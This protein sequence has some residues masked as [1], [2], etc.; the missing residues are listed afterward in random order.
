MSDA[1]AALLRINLALAA[2]VAVILLLRRPV[3][4]LVGPR[5]AYG[6][7]A[8]APL[9][10]LAMLAPPRIMRVRV[11][12]AP[13]A[14]APLAPAGP[15]LASPASHVA[16]L[17]P[18]LAGLWLAGAA[19]SLLL[20]AW[21]Q[22][23]FARAM[24]AGRAGPAVVGVLRPRIVTPADFARRYTEREQLVVLAHER[25]HIVRQDPR[26]NAA[27]ALARC[28]AW[29]NPLAHLAATALR[30][31]QELACDAQVVAAH[32]GARRA[33]AEAM[34]KTQL[35]ARPLP[36]GCYWPSP[37]AHPLAERI[38]LLAR[39][40]P[41]P[42]QRHLGAAGLGL[43]VLGA[44][45]AAWAA[46]PPEVRFDLQAY[47]PP[48]AVAPAAA[49]AAAPAPAPPRLKP[50]RP[51]PPLAA[52]P[53]APAIPAAF[54]TPPPTP[55]DSGH[56]GPD[57]HLLPPGAEPPPFSRRIHAAARF[58]SVEPGSAVRVLA[59]MTDPDGVPLVTDLTAF[60][61]QSLY[62]MGYV[63][64]TSSRYKLFTS[65]AQHGDRLEVTAA[66]TSPGAP[67]LKGSV[68]LGSGETAAVPLPGG[69]SVR[70]TPLLRP[71]TPE[72]AEAAAR[73]GARTFVRV[74]RVETP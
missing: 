28:L 26:I 42:A 56:P 31:D 52:L 68:T 69:L 36:L 58:S 32:P 12:D 73:L 15:P 17:G 43:L 29:F 38:A 48:P 4:R 59:T 55:A 65:V 7:W 13:L 30:M 16:D 60:G 71:E 33:Y 45:C 20:V 18:W 57:D 67:M 2:A 9:A 70:V 21:R 72:E 46:R 6:L 14:M 74:D 35:A 10:V 1:L 44:A 11:V 62:R 34:L 41:G 5:L 25:T 19:A 47:P 23:Q 64:R 37:S 8:L 63:S 51:A 50:A 24:R 3:R 61:S 39:R 22:G 53:P 27:V 40:S 49:V 66:V 54:V